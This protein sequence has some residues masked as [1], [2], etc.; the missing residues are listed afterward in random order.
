MQEFD[1]NV[2]RKYR[3]IPR[4][5]KTFSVYKSRGTPKTT[6]KEFTELVT[7]L[8]NKRNK[9]RAAEMERE[10]AK[11]LDGFRVPMSGAGSLKGDVLVEA[12]N[13]KRGLVECKTTSSMDQHG[14]FFRLDLFMMERL[15]KN[16][17]QMSCPLAF[18]VFRFFA[19][20]SM[21]VLMLEESYKDLGFDLSKL[22]CVDP[23]ETG[24]KSRKF[25]LIFLDNA[26]PAFRCVFR[27]YNLVV[28]RFDLFVQ[29][30]KGQVEPDDTPC[31]DHFVELYYGLEEEEIGQPGISTETSD[32]EW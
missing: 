26:P 17:A 31:E 10:V 6:Y 11:L 24:S 19:K 27:P 12:Y 16:A 28:V 8:I 15:I 9:R 1:F 3:R 5:V 30:L 2:L 29:L 14:N 20:P 7:S 4:N 13:G 23:A 21:F 32:T 25:H 22:A 18:V